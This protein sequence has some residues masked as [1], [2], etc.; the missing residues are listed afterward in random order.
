MQSNTPSSKSPFDEWSTRLFAWLGGIVAIL[1]VFEWLFQR[2]RLVGEVEQIITGTMSDRTTGEI[3]AN[4]MLELYLVNTRTA[5]TTVRG[6]KARATP[7]GSRKSHDGVLT[8]IPDTF[9]LLQGDGS[10]IPI[11]WAKVRL[12]DL[13]WQNALG[14]ER[15]MRGWLRFTFKGLHGDVLR[16]ECRFHITLID[17]RKRKHVIKYISGRGQFD[18]VDYLPGGGVVPPKS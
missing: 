16:K 2:P 3:A 15:P 7:A 5:P 17:A 6:W 4:V 10:S 14:R 12:Y 11:D 1:R 13:A 9:Q 18:V 8:T